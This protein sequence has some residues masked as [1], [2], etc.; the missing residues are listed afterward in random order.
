MKWFC[1]LLL[2]FVSLFCLD[3]TLIKFCDQYERPFSILDLY[4]S[5]GELAFALAKKYPH[6]TVILSSQDIGLKSK[7]AS[8]LRKQCKERPELTNIVLLTA[9]IN[10]SDAEKLASSEHFDLLLTEKS[11]EEM[12]IPKGT[13]T[14]YILQLLKQASTHL[15]IKG[16]HYS[17]NLHS[18]LTKHLLMR[19]GEVTKEYTVHPTRIDTLASKSGFGE[20]KRITRP[21]GITLL[22]Y[23]T[24]R[25]IWPSRMMILQQLQDREV[26]QTYPLATPWNVFVTGTSLAFETPPQKEVA[27]PDPLAPSLWE[28]LDSLFE[29]RSKHEFRELIEDRY[30]D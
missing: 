18:H 19:D 1:F 28:I 15:F 8:N 12:P 14:D 17:S 6:A 26:E 23:L 10:V 13:S 20:A 4:A 24:Y 27:L 29:C 25:G 7:H 3:D 5:D 22:T 2:P 30:I 11:P 16:E 9:Q 21:P